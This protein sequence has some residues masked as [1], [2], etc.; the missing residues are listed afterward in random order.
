MSLE[1]PSRMERLK[2]AATD[3]VALAENGTELGIVSYSDDAE[4][5]SGHASVPVT[6]LGTNRAAWNNAINGLAPGGWTNIG[7]GLQK[8]MDMIA[9][10]GGV[11]ANTFIVLMT[12]GINNRPAPQ[13]VADADLQAKIDD[14]SD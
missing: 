11:T 2:V 1:T 10:A 14:L 3:F 9:A 6:A 5:A 7:D 8:A 13:A 12:D 4:A